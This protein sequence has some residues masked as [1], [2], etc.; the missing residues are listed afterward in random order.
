M[1]TQIPLGA[2]KDAMKGIFTHFRQVDE[3]MTKT[4][5]CVETEIVRDGMKQKMADSG[6]LF[7]LIEF[8]KCFPLLVKKDKNTSSG[9]NYVMQAQKD[10]MVSDSISNFF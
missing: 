10:Q 6:K 7:T 9:M 2:F 5:E 3:I 4:A 8:I 1:L